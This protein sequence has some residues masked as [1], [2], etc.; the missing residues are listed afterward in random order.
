MVTIM[1]QFFALRKEIL[2]SFIV[3][4]LHT[5]GHYELQKKTPHI[6]ARGCY[7]MRVSM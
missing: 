5:F 3:T 4:F 2:A 7:E 6:S 1:A